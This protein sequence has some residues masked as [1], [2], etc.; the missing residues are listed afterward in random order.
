MRDRDCARSL[1]GTTRRRKTR[2]GLF[3]PS[4]LLLW[5]AALL[6]GVVTNANSLPAGPRQKRI[7]QVRQQQ[8]D[9]DD[10]DDEN[11]DAQEICA[12]QPGYYEFT[13]DFASSCPD[14]D[15]EDTVG[16]VDTACILTTLGNENVTD[17]V[18]ATVSAVSILELDQNS[19]VVA[20]KTLTDQTLVGGDTFEYTS[21]TETSPGELDDSS[22]LPKGIQVFLSAQN[23]MGEDLVNFFAIEY[24][25]AECTIAPILSVGQ[26]IGWASIVRFET[27]P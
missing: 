2:L 27:L 12:C 18:P 16:V 26:K 6:V 1:D 19:Q 4:S 3:D 24:D 23:A 11:A 21:I 20:Q 9:S 10:T 5:I 7:K 22:K 8:D 17:L 14:S 15:I 13:L 25:S